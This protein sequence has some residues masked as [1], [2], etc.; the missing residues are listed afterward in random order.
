MYYDRPEG[1]IDRL[2]S[3]L[4]EITVDVASLKTDEFRNPRSSDASLKKNNEGTKPA[5]RS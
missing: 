4:L 5:I 2:L 1:L 3:I